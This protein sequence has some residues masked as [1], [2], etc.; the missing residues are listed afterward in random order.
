MENKSNN[1]LTERFQKLAGLTAINEYNPA[2]RDP[3]TFQEYVNKLIDAMSENF[4]IMGG[5]NAAFYHGDILAD[6]M[7]GNRTDSPGWTGFKVKIHFEKY[8]ND[9]SKTNK[10]IGELK[11][12]FDYNNNKRN[13]YFYY[14]D[15][16][17]REAI[18]GQRAAQLTNFVTDDEMLEQSYRIGDF[19]AKQVTKNDQSITNVDSATASDELFEP[20]YTPFCK[21]NL[22]DGWYDANIITGKSF[23]RLGDCGD[24]VEIAQEFINEIIYKVFNDLDTLEPDGMYGPRTI[25]AVKLVQAKVGTNADGKYGKS[26][27]DAISKFLAAKP[28][29]DQLPV[30]QQTELDSN[31]IKL[32]DLVPITPAVSNSTG[33]KIIDRIKAGKQKRIEKRIER[34][35]KKKAKFTRPKQF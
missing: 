12:Y 21:R 16:N 32:G 5:T 11:V 28:K 10:Q 4:G 35:N 23:L 3:S 1:M 31:P 34:L 20:K 15:E 33:Q 14:T 13:N 26:T 24:A 18:I 8:N 29:I 9:D 22:K 17:M 30:A 27:H 19:M 6:R 7:T 2:R 25:N